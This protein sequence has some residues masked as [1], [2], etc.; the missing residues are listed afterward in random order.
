VVWDNAETL[1]ITIRQSTSIRLKTLEKTKISFSLL[2]ILTSTL[3][4]LEEITVV[5]K[6]KKIHSWIYCNHMGCQKQKLLD[7]SEAECSAASTALCLAVWLSIGRS[8]FSWTIIKQLHFA[9]VIFIT[10]GESTLIP[11]ITEVL[12]SLHHRMYWARLGG[13][14]A[15]PNR[16]VTCKYS[17]KIAW[18]SPSLIKKATVS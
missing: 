6:T 7:C 15:R 12:L 11:T 3:L 1:E 16:R 2:P 18:N 4:S 8:N 10:R 14:R 9:K 5:K 13:C 17:Y